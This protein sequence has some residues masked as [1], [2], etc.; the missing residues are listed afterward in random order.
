MFYPLKIDTDEVWQHMKSIAHKCKRKG[1]TAPFMATRSCY[2][3]LESSGKALLWTSEMP[4]DDHFELTFEEWLQE[5]KGCRKE[6]KGKTVEK[7]IVADANSTQTF[8]SA[9]LAK[10]YIINRVR[11]G[12]TITVRKEAQYVPNEV[13]TPILP[14]G[15]V[16]EV[17]PIIAEMSEALQD[18]AFN[19]GYSRPFKGEYID[20]EAHRLI[21]NRRCK[22]IS[23]C[24]GEMPCE[25][26]GRPHLCGNLVKVSIAEAIMFLQQDKIIPKPRVVTM[27][28]V[29]EKFGEEV[30]IS[31]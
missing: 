15:D 19:R 20:T 1:D 25:H 2:L 31:G 10:S 29:T 7:V 9:E 11:F 27:R 3:T 16:I 23:Y 21:F 30:I 22:R 8:T 18:M 6:R 28:E 17:D 4:S 24:S 13:P 26:C 12:H 5:L 14:T